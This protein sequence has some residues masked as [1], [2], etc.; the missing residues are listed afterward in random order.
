MMTPEE[1]TAKLL[2]TYRHID[3]IIKSPE[4][5]NNCAADPDLVIF[6]I[7]SHNVEAIK[8]LARG[9]TPLEIMSYGQLRNEA[10]LRGIRNYSRMDKL[11]LLRALQ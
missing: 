11:E 1:Y 2:R 8:C 4:F 9:G 6:L 10:R 3:K 5:K 7:E